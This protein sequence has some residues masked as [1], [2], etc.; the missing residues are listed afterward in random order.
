MSDRDQEIIDLLRRC[1][2]AFQRGDLEAAMEMA[3]PE[4][5]ASPR[6]VRGR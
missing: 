1:Y 4:I 2:E 5:E 6:G 3:H